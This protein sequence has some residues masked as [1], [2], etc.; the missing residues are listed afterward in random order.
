MLIVAELGEDAHHGVGDVVDLAGRH[1]IVQ[2]KARIRHEAD[3][4]A[5]GDGH[6]EAARTVFRGGGAE[7]EIVDARLG[8]IVGAALEAD[9]ELARQ[10]GAERMPQQV[11]RQRLRVRRDVEQFV[12]GDA[13]ERA[14]GDVAHRVAARLARRDPGVGE[15]PHGGL[16]VVQLHEMELH[17]LPRG[18]VA[19][20]AR[21][22]VRDVGERLELRAGQQPLRDLDAQHLRVLRLPLAVGAAHE[23]EGPPLVGPD[24]AALEP[25]EH[26]GELVDLRPVGEAQSRPAIRVGIINY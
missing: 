22:E 13:G 1:E 17:V 25:C 9:L 16:D 19:E 8:V 14:G 23:P 6:A 18:D 2:K 7:A 3:R 4:G 11:A 20:A 10:L 21:I 26:V 24:L 5:A 15:A 12:G